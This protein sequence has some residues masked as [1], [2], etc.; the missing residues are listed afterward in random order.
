MEETIQNYW[1]SIVANN[2]ILLGT[3]LRQ[4][5]H[6]VKSTFT[7][8]AWHPKAPFADHSTELKNPNFNFTYTAL[9]TAAVHSFTEVGR[10]LLD[11]GADPNAIGY[12]DNKGL[13]PPVV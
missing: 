4:H 7:G 12:E 3:L 13:T 2:T 5:P 11:H 6:L 8:T 9:H 10:L 1:Q